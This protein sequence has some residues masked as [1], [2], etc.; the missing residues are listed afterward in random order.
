MKLEPQVTNLEL[1]KRLKELGVY[2]DSLFHWLGDE[3]FLSNE[4]PLSP[5]KS[6]KGAWPAYTCGELGEML[7]KGILVQKCHCVK[8]THLWKCWKY[9]NRPGVIFDL[10]REDFSADSIANAM[11]K[12]L[13]YLL[14]NKIMKVEEL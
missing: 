8:D 1:S 5:D 3:L 14:E 13:I 4:L 11:A 12:M 2:E 10:E 6:N 7:P 9:S